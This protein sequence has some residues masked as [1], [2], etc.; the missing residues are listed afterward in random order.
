MPGRFGGGARFITNAAGM[1]RQARGYGLRQAISGSRLGGAG[2]WA[3]AHPRTTIGM[4]LGA[5]A[6]IGYGMHRSSG[7]DGIRGR[8]SGGF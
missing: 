4:G 5:G 3:G 8:S 2:R 6:G 7:R 1:T